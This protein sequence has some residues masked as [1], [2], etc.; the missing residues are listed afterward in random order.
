MQRCKA[1]R[2]LVKRTFQRKEFQ[3]T[4]ATDQGKTSQVETQM[5]RHEKAVVVLHDTLTALEERLATVLVEKGPELNAKDDGTN[6][7]AL[8]CRLSSIARGTMDAVG[9]IRDIIERLEL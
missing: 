2:S 3:M 5:E 1:K 9:R 6:F 4:H 7:V 8:A